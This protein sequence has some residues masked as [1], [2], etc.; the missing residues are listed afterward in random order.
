MCNFVYAKGSLKEQC[1][2]ICGFHYVQF[3]VR[4]RKIQGRVPWD[5]R[6]QIFWKICGNIHSSRCTTIVA[7]IGANLPP[8]SLIL[9]ANCHWCHWHRQQNLLPVSLTLVENLQRRALKCFFKICKSTNSSAQCKCKS[10]N[11]W[12]MRVCKFHICLPQMWQILW[13]AHLC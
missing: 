8:V 5:F 3:F 12:D 7:D 13:A 10:A 9:V 6:L 11:F 2:E 4:K 1:L